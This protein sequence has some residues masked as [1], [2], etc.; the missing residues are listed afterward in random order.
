MYSCICV[1]NSIKW[2]RMDGGK[3]PSILS[4]FVRC[5]RVVTVTLRSLSCRKNNVNLWT[6]GKVL[7]AGP[8]PALK[9]KQSVTLGSRRETVKLGAIKIRKK[10]FKL[11]QE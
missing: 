10:E 7:S 8:D 6:G 11:Y 5:R 1:Q 3:A 2:K 9:R 4:V